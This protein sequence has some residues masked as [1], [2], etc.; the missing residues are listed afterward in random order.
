MKCKLTQGSSSSRATRIKTISSKY[1]SPLLTI[2]DDD[3]GL[4]D[5]LELQNANACYLKV[6]AITPPTWKNHLVNHLD[7]ELL[8][9]HDRCY[10]RQA[11]VDNV[12]NKRSW[13]LLKVIEQIRGV[14]GYIRKGQKSKQNDKTEHENGKSVKEKS[15]SK[16]S[17][18]S[19][20]KVNPTKSRKKPRK[21]KAKI[22]DLG[23]QE[24]LKAEMMVGFSSQEKHNTHKKEKTKDLTA[25]ILKKR[26]EDKVTSVGVV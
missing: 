22:K 14:N 13:E 25:Y 1:A 4:P 23:G 21:S 12:V 15:K 7:V 3:K 10:A 16:P 2:F 17:E 18:K 24:R 8:D 26:T 19:T 9:L 6:F 5:V 11:N 20:V